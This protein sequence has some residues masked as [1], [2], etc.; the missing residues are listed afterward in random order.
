MNPVSCARLH[1]SIVS[2]PGLH[3]QAR[4]IAAQLLRTVGRVSVVY[5]DSADRTES[6]AGDWI[7]VP[8]KDYFGHK[9]QVLLDRVNDDDVMLLIQADASCEDWPE[10]ARRCAAALEG[11]SS[12]GV[13]APNIDNSSFPP[14]QMALR[15]HPEMNLVEVLNCDAIVLGLAPFVVSRLRTLDYACNNLGWGIDWAAIT[16]AKAAGLTAVVDLT[17]KVHHPVSRGYDGA[18]AESQMHEFLAQLGAPE[19]D[20][21][22]RF[23]ALVAK[24]SGWF[25]KTSHVLMSVLKDRAIDTGRDALKDH[26]GA[27]VVAHGKIGLINRSANQK[28]PRLRVDAQWI[29]FRPGQRAALAHV[30]SMTLPDDEMVMATPA[31]DEWTCPGQATYSFVFPPHSG[32]RMVEL[33]APLQLPADSG[34]V[35]LVVGVANHRCSA[36]LLVEW[37]DRDDPHASQKVY[38]KLDRSFSGRHSLGDY[39]PVRLRLPATGGTR[40][41]TLT[42]CFWG[43]SENEGETGVILITRPFLLSTFD[44][45]APSVPLVILGD[46]PI[47]EESRWLEALIP[48]D[49]D[50]VELCFGDTRIALPLVAGPE[51][52][53][54]RRDG[55]IF[56]SAAELLPV[57]LCLNGRAT[58]LLWL[59][60]IETALD[61]PGRIVGDPGMRV[62]LR[63]MT[64]SVVLARG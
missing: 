56:A 26:V 28:I 32:E 18:A 61:L 52:R 6:G 15:Q 57:T 29:P 16:H 10:L 40:V 12:I 3:D 24:R 35:T 21:Y 7:R 27:L 60:L 30:L 53:L 8:Q 55:Q 5:S 19:R 64:G 54:I 17:M 62:E 47:C 20:A 38:V 44:A 36:D 22:K 46:D 2:W 50:T 4:H 39:Q 41:L 63:D 14:E 42:L 34:D 33:T 9:F 51:V 37:Q 48:P 13:W 45:E 31:N 1:A 11:A 23:S 49:A 59:G 43:A 25:A 58:R